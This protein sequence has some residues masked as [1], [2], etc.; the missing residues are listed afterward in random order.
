MDTINQ[1]VATLR[2]ASYTER[3]GI[4]EQLLALVR[5]PG[6]PAM[7]E[8]LETAR[9]GEL[10]EV[11]WEIEEVLEKT[12]PP[13]PAAAAPPPPP[14][15]EKPDPNKPL[16]AKDLVLVYDDP[17][18]LVLHK[19]KVGNRWFATQVDPKTRQP[20][21]FELHP[22]EI[23]QLKTQLAGSPYWALGHGPVAAPPAP[24]RPA[25]R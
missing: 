3:E 23:E 8:A 20:Q 10:L 7:R 21:T 6:G 17:R 4:K 15:E 13:K 9:K 1:L 25:G 19:S 11:Q 2:Q 18:G 24:P 22:Q 12:A 14:P 16:T 5:G